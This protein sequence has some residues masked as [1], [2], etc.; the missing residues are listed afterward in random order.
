MINII[1]DG[2]AVVPSINPISFFKQIDYA[3][4]TQ[5]IMYSKIAAYLQVVCD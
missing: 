5:F 2:T 1:P 4:F 3:V